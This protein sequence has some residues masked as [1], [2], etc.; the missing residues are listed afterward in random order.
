ML[1]DDIT[2]SRRPIF[3]R[4]IRASLGRAPLWLLCWVVPFLLALVVAVPWMGWFDGALA[5]RYEPR[6]VLGSMDVNFR[7]DHRAAQETLRVEGGRATAL[8]ALLAMLVGIFTSGGWLQVFLE[9]TSGHS[10]RRFLW[11]GARYF[12]RFVRVWIV[13]LLTLALL[14]WVLMGWPW[15]TLLELGLG[16]KDG[17][18]EVVSSEWTALWIGWVQAGLYATGVALVLAWGDYTRTRIALHEGHSAVW[19]GLCTWFLIFLHPV[20]TLRPFLLLLVLEVGVVFAVGLLAWNANTG[21]GPQSGWGVVALLFVLGQLAL[22]WQAIARAA[23]YSAAVQVSHQLVEPLARPDPWASRVG[24]PG[25][26]QY[27]IGD[28][29]DYGVSI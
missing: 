13:T 20:R 15:K 29:D 28:S 9:R 4:A 23:R 8:L 7:F 14:S 27:P 19:A 21:I 10:V 2:S 26:P 1:E 18:L 16:A 12:W 25:G 5:N 17:N 22:I 6:S 11:G 24:G 3:L